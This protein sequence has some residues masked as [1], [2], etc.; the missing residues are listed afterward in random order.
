M[1]I[2]EE[3]YILKPDT[4]EEDI[5]ASVEQIRQIVTTAGG[6]IDKVDKWGI[7]KLAYRVGK[8]SEG[9]YVLVQFSSTPET[10]RELERRLRVSDIVLKYLT[11]RIDEKLKWLEKR[12]KIREK[13]AARK[14]APAPLQPAPAAP[15]P[16]MPG[17]PAAP[18]PGPAPE[19]P[20]ANS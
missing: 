9:Y 10:V 6:T 16:A 1:R 11:V 4:A 7:R 15:A 18:V 8:Q 17:E 20:V 5:E 12:K 13:R 2:Y 3:L 19:A 14:P